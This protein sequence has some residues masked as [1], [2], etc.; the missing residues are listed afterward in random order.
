MQHLGLPLD[1]WRRT[2]DRDGGD[3]GLQLSLQ[4]TRLLEDRDVWGKVLPEIEAL[5]EEIDITAYLDD[6]Q[7]L[8]D[9]LRHA[10]HE[11]DGQRIVDAKGTLIALI[12]EIGQGAGGPCFPV[13]A[14]LGD[15][16]GGERQLSIVNFP[17]H[18]LGIFPAVANQ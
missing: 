15:D 1:R 2:K 18:V 12:N 4:R 5:P 9:Q 8:L 13:L 11:D 14:R 6:V 10:Y 16:R 3:S 17:L 7:P